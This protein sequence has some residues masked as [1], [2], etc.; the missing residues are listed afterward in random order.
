MAFPLVDEIPTDPAIV[1]LG[2]NGVGVAVGV[3]FAVGVAVEVGFTTATPLFQIS[4]LPL[5]MQVY[6]LPF[7]VEVS[8][9]FLH[10]SPDLTA[11]TDA[12]GAIR[13]RTSAIATAARFMNVVSNDFS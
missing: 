6:F 11:A 4:F 9:A 10:G 5:L 13:D 1:T 3:G 7:A 12:V 2:F 8:P